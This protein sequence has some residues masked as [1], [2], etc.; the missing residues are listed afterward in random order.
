[1]KNIDKVQLKTLIDIIGSLPSLQIAHF[2]NEEDS[3]SDMLNEYCHERGYLYQINTSDRSFAEGVSEKLR[4][5]ETTQV[6]FFPLERNAYMI[7]GRQYDFLFV[8]IEIEDALKG[9]FLKKVHKIMRNAGNI[10]IFIPKGD[11]K[12][13]YSWT[14]LLEEHYFVATS[15]INDLFENYDVVISKK[16]HGWGG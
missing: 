15:T 4:D 2:T 3:L 6:K 1:M 13:R 10:I 16:M 7:Q 9:D 8:S 12:T 14:A 5:T 11:R